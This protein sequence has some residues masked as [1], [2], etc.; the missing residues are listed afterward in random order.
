M[1]VIQFEMSLPTPS[2]PHAPHNFFNGP[3]CNLDDG[4]CRDAVVGW[5]VGWWL[6]Q[7]NSL[8]GRSGDL[9][10]AIIAG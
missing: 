7:I 10:L 8:G 6:F 4:S 9:G 5:Y 2:F 3:K 1:L